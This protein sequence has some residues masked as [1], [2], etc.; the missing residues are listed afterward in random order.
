LCQDAIATFTGMIAFIEISI[1]KNTRMPIAN[2]LRRAT[3]SG[4]RRRARAIGRPRKIVKPANAPS[5][6][7]I[8]NDSRVG[9]VAL[10][11]VGAPFG[12]ARIIASYIAVRRL[13]VPS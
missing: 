9:G 13:G 3:V 5:K 7:V 12:S 8:P 6:T 1:T 11:V 2:A 10:A 4:F